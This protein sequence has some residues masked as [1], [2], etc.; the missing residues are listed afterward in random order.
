MKIQS[1]KNCVNLAYL[2]KLSY[3]ESANEL[4]YVCGIYYDCG[5]YD[6]PYHLLQSHRNFSRKQTYKIIQALICERLHIDDYVE[7]LEYL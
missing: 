3:F 7:K 4:F 1:K 5:I 2:N 6:K